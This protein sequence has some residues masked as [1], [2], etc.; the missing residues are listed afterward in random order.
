MI[1]L[2]RALGGPELWIKRDDQTGL[3][4]GGNKTRKL[5]FLMADAHEQGADTVVTQGATQ[6]N[7]V[8]QTVA[9]AAK[10][11]FKCHVVLE[12]L[13][14]GDADYHRSGN[15]LLD[16]IMGATLHP[17]PPADDF[18][19][20]AREI[21]AEIA[22]KTGREPYYLPRGGSNPV[23]ALGYID[24][25]LELVKQKRSLNLDFSHIVHA[26]GS[27]GTQAGLLVG[28]EA[29]APGITVHG[30]TVSRGAQEQVQKVAQLT[31]ATATLA[32]LEG[33][34]GHDR[35]LC[36]DNYFLPGYGEASESTIEAITMTAREEGILLDPVYT[37][38]A[39]AGLI[40]KVRDGELTKGDT[41]VFLHTGGA[42]ALF[43]YKSLF[44]NI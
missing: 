24:C 5:E 37:G 39:M 4:T 8:R 22:S 44:D 1:N 15:L 43:A 20:V 28:L 13:K 12:T 30:I 36:D 19:V 21:V 29:A 31:A 9:A 41:V 10:L 26:T 7:H 27:Q 2:S 33:G 40:G 42:A 3:A 34:V 38:K 16:R 23:G 18:D 32:R 35:V 11:G 17:R 25:A 14:S 6:S